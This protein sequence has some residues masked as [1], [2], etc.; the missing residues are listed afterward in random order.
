M[1]RLLAQ[2]GSD[3]FVPPALATGLGGREADF[4][5]FLAAEAT[6]TRPP[7]ALRSMF[8]LLSSSIVHRGDPAQIAQLASLAATGG[9][10]PEWARL[11]IVAGFEG[12]SR[13][14]FRR[15]M[16]SGVALTSAEVAPLK[17]SADAGVGAA[18]QKI[19]SGLERLEAAA[20][21][22]AASA[23]PLTAAETKLYEA[24]RI[25]FQLCAACHQQN[26]GGLPNVAPSLVD[27]HWVVARPELPIRIVLDGK[28]GTLGFPG[29]MPPIGGTFSDE[30]IAGVLTYI[31]NSW[32]LHA[33]AVG[34]ETVA[35]VRQQVKGRLAAWNDKDLTRVENELERLNR[36]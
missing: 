4:M 5:R 36:R 35:K 30:Q 11:A 29:A 31:R 23:R 17:D 22:R 1:D 3:S 20:R 33:G 27:S 16:R 7:P 9:G 6:P 15:S 12:Y 34:V 14:A 2:A 10:L 13:P 26:G 18:G 28:E 8:A 32:G 24:G 19:F 25:T 21:A